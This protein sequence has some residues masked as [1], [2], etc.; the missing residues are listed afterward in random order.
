MPQQEC[1]KL[2]AG[3]QTSSNRILSGAGEVSN[4]LI[5]LIRN[6]NCNQVARASQACQRYRITPIRLDALGRRAR[7]ATG[8]NHLAVEPVGQQLARQ[9]ITAGAR[10][11][12]H[13][14]RARRAVV[15]QSLTNLFKVRSDGADEVRYLPVIA[16]GCNSDGVL[17]DIQS[18][19]RSD[20]LMHGLPP[21]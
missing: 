15:T 4:G 6:P 13:L 2:L 12:D 16:G 5:T 11:V 18:D 9:R 8:G 1:F 20:T 19:V 3:L 17:V 14:Q 10:L 7:D 21:F